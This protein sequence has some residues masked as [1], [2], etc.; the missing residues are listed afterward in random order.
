MLVCDICPNSAILRKIICNK[1]TTFQLK[2]Q[3]VTAGD[4]HGLNLT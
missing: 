4:E 1:L 2:E 3:T